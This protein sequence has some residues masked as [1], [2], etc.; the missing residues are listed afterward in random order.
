MA[1]HGF[2]RMG[3]LGLLA[4]CLLLAGCRRDPQANAASELA[5]SFDGSA[6][7]E[8][9]M[10]AKAAFE[11]GRYRDVLHLLHKVV[12]RD[13]LTAQQRAAIGGMVGQVLQ[14]VH[15]DPQLSADPQIHRLMEVLILRTMGE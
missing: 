7:K 8:D 3:A 9:A 13:D 1:K 12:G 6:V 15:N 4:L 11:E 2:T 10:A 14:A 5:A